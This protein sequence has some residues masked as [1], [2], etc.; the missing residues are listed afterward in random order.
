MKVS[1][2]IQGETIKR[3]RDGLAGSCA[4]GYRFE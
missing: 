2:G 3:L 4:P 1:V